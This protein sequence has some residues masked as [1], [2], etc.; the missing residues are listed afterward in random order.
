MRIRGC[1]VLVALASAGF[2]RAETY[3]VGADTCS[4]TS[5]Q[6]AL[7]AAA[8]NPGPDVIRIAT[9]ATYDAQ[10]LKI[11]SQDVSLLG[12]Y[13]TCVS[14]TPGGVT[15]ISGLGGAAD[16]VVEISGGADVV[17]TGLRISD[18]DETD[19]GIGGGID[20]EG[21][22]TLT[23]QNVIVSNNRAGY[24]G[25]IAFEALGK[26]TLGSDVVVQNNV[27]TRSGGGVR[28]AGAPFF[29]SRDTQLVMVSPRSTVI[30]NQALGAD[31]DTG[32]G[33]G[34]QIIGPAYA[35][36]ASPG[37]VNFGAIAFNRARYG[38]GI[39][40]SV[41]DN[42]DEEDVDAVL[43]SVDPDHP[44]RVH[45]NIASAAGG[46]AFLDINHDTGPP[47]LTR[48]AL[49]GYETRVDHNQAPEG[50]AFYLDSENSI[51][52]GGFV[53]ARVHLN[54]GGCGTAGF[55][56]EPDAV[57]CSRGIACNQIDGN[58]VAQ[59]DGTPAD[60]AVV[61]IQE[62]GS[63][64]VDRTSFLDNTGDDV[65]HGLSS[66]ESQGLVLTNCLIANN[67]V[68]ARAIA[69]DLTTTIRNCTITGNTLGFSDVLALTGEATLND[70]IVW[71]P[72]HVTLGA[73]SATG[74]HVLTN[75]PG[76][77]PGLV[78]TS[79]QPRF[80]DPARRDYRLRAASPAV[81]FAPAGTGGGTD[82]DNLPHNRDLANIDAFGPRDLGA[83]ERQSISP[84]VLNANF[85][86]DATH[87]FDVTAGVSGFDATENAPG[88]PA[89]GS[90]NFV[91]QNTP[92]AQGRVVSRA[93]CIHLPLPGT[94]RLNGSARTTGGSGLVG[95]AARLHF[96]LRHDGTEACTSGP[97]DAQADLHITGGTAW[98]RASTPA[99]ITIAPGDFTRNSSITVALV[100]V[101][102]GVTFPAS[103]QGWFDD[104]TL[105]LDLEEL[106]EDG[107]E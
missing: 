74:G 104:V 86:A 23:L 79:A 8:G 100:M 98:A 54:A 77:L 6:N 46:A 12:G 36:I 42:G 41:R 76:S 82:L 5:I 50:A 45:G 16:S 94:Y 62:D 64:I 22:G 57:R 91:W 85:N 35:R 31:D 70:S 106:F 34:I 107:F 55:P 13:A 53:G 40:L 80:V 37:Y 17:L 51:S 92:V 73:G 24:G 87:W 52:T 61:E 90:M 65:I 1:A 60:G 33:G 49:C 2:A 78:A 101:A 43:Y 96:A 14:P 67:V 26:L 66:E 29:D 44:V 20:F 47:R 48:T 102:T 58:V 21:S 38:G 103:M 83:Y 11:V 81:D 63:F 18:G 89:G 99:S 15:L 4:F 27:A 32:Y 59:A 88:S 28:V 68:E 3:T 97:I 95:Q 93:Q 9:N 71:Q 69:V 72:G 30:F 56:P 105:T 25:G 7:N 84:L 10:A 39:A 19:S 75:D